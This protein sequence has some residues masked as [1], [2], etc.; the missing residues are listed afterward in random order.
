MQTRSFRN[1]DEEEQEGEHQ[2]EKLSRYQSE[3]VFRAFEGLNVPRAGF[4]PLYIWKGSTT[5]FGHANTPLRKAFIRFWSNNMRPERVNIRRYA[6]T[7]RAFSVPLSKETQ[8]ELFKYNEVHDEE[9][10][11]RDEEK[12]ARDEAHPNYTTT[13]QGNENSDDVSLTSV[14]SSGLSSVHKEF[15]KM[16]FGESLPSTLPTSASEKTPPKSAYSFRSTGA[17]PFHTPGLAASP[18]RSGFVKPAPA[19]CISTSSHH[20]P[21]ADY[22]HNGSRA[23]PFPVYVEAN[24][25]KIPFMNLIFDIHPLHSIEYDK[26]EHKGWSVR[27]SVQLPDIKKVE[28]FIPKMLPPCFSQYKRSSIMYKE[29]AINHF[30]GQIDHYE[31]TSKIQDKGTV[32]SLRI[33]KLA[34][35]SDVNNEDLAYQYFLILFPLEMGPIDNR[36]LSGHSDILNVDRA[37]M[38]TSATENLYKKD[39]YGAILTWRIALEDQSRQLVGLEDEDNP[40][41][42]FA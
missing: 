14:A 30:A 5:F 36:I 21:V 19:S 37:P 41:D 10:E 24:N 38:L 16:N 9:K 34:I 23:Y 13:P 6:E 35:E 22:R 4:K 20:G 32:N 39:L 12:E 11:A 40:A 8:R 33:A 1:T 27:T 28:M 29:P 7:L 42:F 26:Q 17:S 15:E 18:F 2:L 25:N 31:K 3:A